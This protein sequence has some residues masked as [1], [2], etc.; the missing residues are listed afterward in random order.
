LSEAIAQL[1]AERSD[2]MCFLTGH[3]EASL[4]DVSPSGLSQLVDVLKRSH[5]ESRR[6]PL[7]APHPETELASCTALALVGPERPLPPSHTQLLERELDAGKHLWVLVDPIVSEH[8]ALADLGLGALLARVGVEM[9]PGFVLE[10]DPAARLPSGMGETFF[11]R[12]LNHPITQGLSTDAARFD[13]RVLFSAAA[14]LLATTG[15]TAQPLLATS[16]RA[17]AL[18]DLRHPEMKTRAAR[19]LVLAYANQ[20][21]AGD[22]PARSVVVAN[23]NLARNEAFLDPSQYGSRVFLENSLAWLFSRTALVSI[24]PRQ[25]MNA[26][27]NLSEESLGALLRYVLIYMPLCAA[28]MGT[29]MMWRRRPRATGSTPR[30][31]ET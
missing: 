11:A 28:T 16:E 27:L 4:D 5:I 8:G 30:G 23:S 14:P 1:T 29:W 3:G 31:G 2:V 24:P 22:A 13:A 15:S 26:G 21:S 9:S 18:L 17:Q 10:A 25:S 20:L 7:D 19:P 12:A 6:T